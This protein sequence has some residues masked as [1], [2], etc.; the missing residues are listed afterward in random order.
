MGNTAEGIQATHGCQTAELLAILGGLYESCRPVWQGGVD[1]LAEKPSLLGAPVPALPSPQPQSP[2]RWELL[3]T[4]PSKGSFSK[5]ASAAGCLEGEKKSKSGQ[6]EWLRPGSRQGASREPPPAGRAPGTASPPLRA[7]HTGSLRP[8][9]HPTAEL[10]GRCSGTRSGHPGSSHQ[11]APPPPIPLPVPPFG[12][13]PGRR[14]P[15]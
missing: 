7:A 8:A 13:P 1:P 14:R 2:P 9:A 4:G 5:A 11:A 15:L 10:R 3:P 12:P 6:S